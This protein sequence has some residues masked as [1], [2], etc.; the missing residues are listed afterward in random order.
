MQFCQELLGTR[1]REHHMNRT[2]E[3]QT[4]YLH[5]LLSTADQAQ[6]AGQDE[7]AIEIIARIY[8]LFPVGKPRRKRKAA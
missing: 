2:Y 1:E 8:K 7:L 3:V 4:L 5:I 6:Q